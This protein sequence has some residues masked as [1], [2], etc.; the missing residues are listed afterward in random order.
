MPII[1][2]LLNPSCSQDFGTSVSGTANE[3][4]VLIIIPGSH[5]W[6]IWSVKCSLILERS[7]QTLST[8]SITQS[9]HIIDPVARCFSDCQSW[10]FWFSALNIH[11]KFYLRCFLRW[12]HPCSSP[13]PPQRVFA[14]CSFLFILEIKGNAEGLMTRIA[15]SI[16]NWCLFIC[17]CIKGL[18]W[19]F[20]ISLGVFPTTQQIR[21]WN[22]EN[23]WP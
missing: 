6:E 9:P 12:F 17:V 5:G 22:V 8:R 20:I 13:S 14:E 11:L 3:F 10:K 15:G 23:N 18:F 7:W 2:Y 4:V 19:F 1:S 21:G 16:S